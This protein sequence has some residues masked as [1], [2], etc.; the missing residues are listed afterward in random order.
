MQPQPDNYLEIKP[1]G[2]FS[3]NVQEL[4]Q[5]REL[6]Y[7][8]VW[9][10]VKVKYKQTIIGLMWVVVQPIALL[11]VFYFALHRSIQSELVYMSYPWYMLTG[12]VLWQYFAVSVSQ[13]AESMIGN[14]NI[15]KKIYF[16]RLIVPIAAVGTALIDFLILFAIVCILFLAK[17]EMHWRS[18]PLLLAGFGITTFAALGLGCFLASANLK[19]RDVRYALPFVLQMLLFTSTVFYPLH[20][21]N[22]LWGKLKYVHPMNIALHSWRCAFSQEPVN[23]SIVGFGLMYSLVILFVG[24]YYFRKTEAFFAD[25]A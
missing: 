11:T 24:I 14:A 4:W 2:R 21:A 17:G 19:Y 1:V 3:L 25:I 8:F 16:P 7:F 20:S 23:V 18:I 22:E 9:R 5:H 10:D 13:S 15:I 6:I 12:L